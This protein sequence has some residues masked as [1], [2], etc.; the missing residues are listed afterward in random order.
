[1]AGI[2]DEGATASARPGVDEG[3]PEPRLAPRHWSP[4]LPPRCG[5]RGRPSSF[6]AAISDAERKPSSSSGELTKYRMVH[7]ATHGTLAGELKGSHE[8]GLIL[9]PPETATETEVGV[10]GMR[11]Q[12]RRTQFNRI[13]ARRRARAAT[14]LVPRRRACPTQPRLGGP[15]GALSEPLTSR[16]ELL[17]LALG[18]KSPSTWKVLQL[19]PLPQCDCAAHQFRLQTPPRCPVVQFGQSRSRAW[20][21]Q[22]R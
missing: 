17:L 20:R 4:H 6:R 19:W 7:F 18:A 9:A 16:S 13:A 3:P 22:G 15:I 21:T 2:A 5:P 8:P 11:W 10:I 14:G 1:M 12:M